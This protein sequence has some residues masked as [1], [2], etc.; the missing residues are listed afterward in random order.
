M[1][2]CGDAPCGE[3]DRQRAA[4]LGRAVDG[5]RRGAAELLLSPELKGKLQSQA[6][7]AGS[8]QV[9]QLARLLTERGERRAAKKRAETKAISATLIL[10]SQRRRDERLAWLRTHSGGAARAGGVVGLGEHERDGG[11]RLR[12]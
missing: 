10:E 9:E 4:Q 1:V 5:A 7:A 8:E 3:P 12:A 2:A 11:S 6:E